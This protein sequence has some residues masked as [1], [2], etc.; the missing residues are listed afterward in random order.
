MD[1]EIVFV[2]LG[3]LSLGPAL[4]CSGHLTSSTALASSARDLEQLRWRDLWFPMIPVA[5]LTAIGLGWALFEPRDSEPVPVWAALAVIPF[6][7]VWC[8][9]IIRTVQSAR[10]C[11]PVAL[12]V[13]GLVHPRVIFAP[14]FRRAT[15]LHVFRAAL[16]HESAHVQHRDPLRILLAQF[17]TDLQWPCRRASAR[18][19]AW[20]AA[21]ELARDEE[22]RLAGAD[23]ADLA[24]AVLQ[25]ARM[26]VPPGLSTLTAIH[27]GSVG[28]RVRIGRLLA[29][30]PPC[31]NVT[32]FSHLRL[33]ALILGTSLAL[34]VGCAWGEQLVQAIFGF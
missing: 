27:D 28:I 7:L 6:G 30:L 1:R 2:I 32:A 5:F 20:K 18:F 13:R 24:T 12:A 8:R 15:D 16:L 29:D 4:F 9:T 22:A 21:L 14:S 34:V 3:M 17:A 25:A 19:T 23:G 10:A 26:V 31:S 33:G 11:P